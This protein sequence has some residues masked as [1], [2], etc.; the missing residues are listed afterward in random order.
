MCKHMM[1]THLCAFPP[2][3][4]SSSLKTS[5][6]VSQRTKRSLTCAQ[7]GTSQTTDAVLHLI[8][9]PG[10][11]SPQVCQAHPMPSRLSCVIYLQIF[12]RLDC[13]RS[14]VSSQAF[15][16]T[17]SLSSTKL[18]PAC[19][20]KLTDTSPFHQ[21]YEKCP[22]NRKAHSPRSFL[23]P[24]L[25]GLGNCAWDGRLSRGCCRCSHLSHGCAGTPAATAPSRSR[26]SPAAGAT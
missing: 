2:C 23:G 1:A 22:L 26:Q 19:G 9:E 14:C 25:L 12:P 6:K 24:S 3:V 20:T 16:E 18:R 11:A 17:P 5:T 4:P 15:M 8:S 7:A 13:C 10:Y 21:R